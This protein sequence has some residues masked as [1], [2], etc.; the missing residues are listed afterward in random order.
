MLIALLAGC[1]GPEDDTGTGPAATWT[2]AFDTSTA[3]A[4]SGVWGSGPDDVY[5]VG[6]DAA[7]GEVWHHDGAGWTEQVVPDGAGLLVWVHGFGPDD[8]WAVGVD[9]TVLHSDGTTW[10][11]LDSGVDVDLWGVFGFTPDDL[12]IVGDTLTGATPYLLH[13]DGAAFTQVAVDPAQNDRGATSMFKVWGLG[14]TLFAVGDKGLVLR[15]DGAAWTRVSG[16]PDAN[17]DL[18][19]LWGTA[20][21]R[22]FMVGGR[23]NARLGEWDGTSWTTHM[24]SGVGG[25]NAVSVTADEVVVGGIYGWVGTWDEVADTLTQETLLTSLDV[26]AMWGDGAGH[27]WAVGG[28]FTDPYEGVAL[29]RTRE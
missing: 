14:D 9:G 27:T 10:T 8:V 13:W 23:A 24:P 12:W 22:M 4:L 6:G 7:G 19:S 26:H 18:V 2:S 29:L 15:W 11:A 5:I 3:G 1:P 28:R 17:D 20:E 21:D 16:G 25:L